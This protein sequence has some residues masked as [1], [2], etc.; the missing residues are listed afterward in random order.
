M[1]KTCLQ[2]KKLLTCALA[3]GVLGAPWTRRDTMADTQPPE[4]GV[5]DTIEMTREELD[6]VV[7]EQAPEY[8]A[9][10]REYVA[11]LRGEEE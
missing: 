10:W 9:A 3:R 4:S 11:P 7:A 6:A 1:A 8:R 5:R 2:E